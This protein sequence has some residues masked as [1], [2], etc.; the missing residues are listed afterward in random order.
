MRRVALEGARHGST[1]KA[2]MDCLAMMWDGILFE[3]LRA[4]GMPLRS[5]PGQQKRAKFPTSK[6]HISAIF[7]S[8]RLISG[9][10]IISRNG[11]EA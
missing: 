2:H 3:Y 9:R 7:H 1:E 8:F 6:A 4:E 5:A 10:A 11:L